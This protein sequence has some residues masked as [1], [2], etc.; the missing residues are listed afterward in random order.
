MRSLTLQPT[1]KVYY[2]SMTEKQG[3]KILFECN[4]DFTELVS[5]LLI[6][7]GRLM[8]DDFDN[9]MKFGNPQRMRDLVPYTYME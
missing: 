3:K 9:L 4:N 8:I 6:R 1:S 7:K 2:L 5:K